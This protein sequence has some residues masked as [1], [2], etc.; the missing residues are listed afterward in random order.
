MATEGKS[1]CK[2]AVLMEGGKGDPYR[3]GRGQ[4][5]DL[6]ETFVKKD[7]RKV[8]ILEQLELRSKYQRWGGGKLCPRWYDLGPAFRDEEEGHRSGSHDEKCCAAK[9]R[10][11]TSPKLGPT[12]R[13][14]KRKEAQN[15]VPIPQQKKEKKREGKKW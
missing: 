11:A 1:T 14:K 4:G 9:T 10:K 12:S 6:N 7:E 5:D 3:K 13:Q 15:H 8:G 2:V